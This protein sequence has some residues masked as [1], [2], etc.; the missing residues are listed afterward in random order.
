MKS[1]VIDR[2]GSYDRLQLREQPEPQPAPGEVRLRVQH[3]GVNYADCVI[4]MG[5]YESAKRLVGWPITPGFEVAGVVD[6]LGDGAEG[7]NAG[8]LAL[9]LTLFGGY[10]DSLCLPAR[11]LFRIPA[12]LDTAQAAALPTIFLTAW[13]AL[14]ELAHLRHGEKVL[15]HS[16]AG[17]VGSAAVQLAARAGAEVTAVVGGAHK[18]EL[19]R[20]LGAAH[21]IVKSE[22][23]LWHEAKRI[24]PG[25]YDVILDPNGVE[26]L[27]HSYAHLAPLGRLAIYGFHSM[28]PRTG[29]VPNWPKLAWDWLRT[30]RFDPL[31]LTVDNR[32]VL[33]FN[34]SFL[35]ERADL[36]IPAM[37]QILDGIARGELRPPPLQ[38]YPL[39]EVARAHRD[40]ESGQTQGKLILAMGDKK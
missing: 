31:K 30:P 10:A 9:G 36:L 18:R 24:A 34:L 4:R 17:G 19:P 11:Q 1:I 16:A 37:T 22:Q 33:G 23:D 13:F 12:G 26:T 8:E 27:G 25:G 38:I 28:L 40:L 29:G 5:L 14:H 35:S 3:A 20:T 6:A 32:S 39:A 21:V 15:V 7:W 2:P